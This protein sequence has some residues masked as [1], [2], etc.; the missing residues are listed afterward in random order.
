MKG[1]N[2]ISSINQKWV[3]EPSP[4]PTFGLPLFTSNDMPVANYKIRKNSKMSYNYRH[5]DFINSGSELWIPQKNTWND[6]MSTIRKFVT[7]N[8]DII[9]NVR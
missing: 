1:M 4:D 6:V 9:V 8:P 5:K 2:D 3:R 7:Q